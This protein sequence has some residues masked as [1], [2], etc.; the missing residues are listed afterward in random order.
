MIID[1]RPING[2]VFIVFIVPE[3]VRS[4]S[5]FQREEHWASDSYSS[6]V[7]VCSAIPN[8]R[9]RL[10]TGAPLNGHYRERFEIKK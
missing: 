1:S 7:G 3:I 5:A 9:R 10:I 8:L 6:S 2:Q 4:P